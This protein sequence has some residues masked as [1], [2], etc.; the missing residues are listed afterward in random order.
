MPSFELRRQVRDF[1]AARLPAAAAG[2]LAVVGPAYLPVGVAATIIPLAGAGG[3][4]E[5]AIALASVL[6]VASTITVIQRSLSVRRQ[7]A[8]LPADGTPPATS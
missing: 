4:P 2:G 7:V 3:S 5:R 8:A 1:L 6:A